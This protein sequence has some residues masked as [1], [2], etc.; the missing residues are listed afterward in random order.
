[1][2]LLISST[3]LLNDALVALEYI[4]LKFISKQTLYRV[5]KMD[6]KIISLYS[7]LQVYNLPHNNYFHSFDYTKLSLNKVWLI[8]LFR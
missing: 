8:N 1:M 2:V 6:I 4:S 7:Q 3:A 5:N